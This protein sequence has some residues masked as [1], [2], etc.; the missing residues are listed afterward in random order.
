MNDKEVNRDNKVIANK[1]ICSEV[2]EPLYIPAFTTL[3]ISLSTIGSSIKGPYNKELQPLK[4]HNSPIQSST[5]EAVQ[6]Q[7]R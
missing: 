5:L 4:V 1:K 2:R 6:S 7:L 3:R